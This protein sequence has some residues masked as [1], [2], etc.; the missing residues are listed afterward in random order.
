VTTSHSVPSAIGS[1]GDGSLRKIATPEGVQLPIALAQRGERATAVLI[2][3][4]IIT[5]VIISIE[6]LTRLGL[7]NQSGQNWLSAFYIVSSFL[8]PSFYFIFFELRWQGTTPGKRLL[9]LRVIDRGGGRLGSDA[10]FARN[11]MRELELFLPIRL[12][13]SSYFDVSEGWQTMLLTVWVF[14]FV[15]LPF[16]NRDYLRAGDIVAGTWVVVIPKETLLSDLSGVDSTTPSEAP[17]M[18]FQFTREQLNVYGIYELQI[19]EQVLRDDGPLAEAKYEEVGKRIQAKISWEEPDETV[20][21]REFLE[22]FYTSLRSH[23]ETGMLFGKR[24]EDK[25]DQSDA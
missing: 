2:D 13:A 24:R 8:V 16:F 20:D 22:A 15:L 12:L 11:L 17:P 18:K 5:V 14:V 1:A 7:A 6:L 9:G 23:L 25:H 4:F 3:L 19:L 21:F 10:V